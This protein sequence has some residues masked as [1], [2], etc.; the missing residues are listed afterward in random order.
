MSRMPLLLA[1]FLFLA[2]PAAAQPP[3][4]PPSRPIA[5]EVGSS[6]SERGGLLDRLLAAV[7]D[8]GATAERGLARGLA[9]R[10]WLRVVSG[11]GEAAIAVSRA[12]R[13][14]SSQSRSK[15]GKKTTVTYRYAVS[16]G[17][18]ITGERDSIEAERSV[19]RTYS[20]GASRQSP[21]RSE[22]RDAF[23]DAGQ[24]LAKKAREWIL[25][26][27]AA[28]RPD[29]P[30]AGLRHEAKFKFLFKGDGLEVTEVAPGGPAARAGLRVGDRIRRIDGES[31]TAQMNERV[32]T[33]RLEPPGT[34]VALEVERDRQRQAMTLELEPP[35]G[36]GRKKPR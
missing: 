7:D 2:V 28:L 20:T 29:G 14:I 16:A 1:I 33:F 27:I 9:D 12:H 19:T 13:S 25:P 18:A 3:R 15:D 6:A 21:T 11:E 17:I 4:L 36:D 10:P 24:E 30:D 22:D 34:R 31:G 5:V 35:P 23:E 8:E 26:R 32:L